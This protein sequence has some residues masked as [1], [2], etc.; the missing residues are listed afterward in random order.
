M[1]LCSQNVSLTSYAEYSGIS[2]NS[3]KDVDTLIEQI[4]VRI[5]S[6]IDDTDII[7]GHSLEN[8]LRAL[9]L[10]H[11]KII[12][13][14]VI[15]RGIN[16]RKFSLKHLSTVLLQRKIQ[17]GCGSYGHCSAEDAEA[18]LVLALRRARRG[19]SF[20][21]KENPK[22]S[23][24]LST[25]QRVNRGDSKQSVGETFA[26]RNDG[27]CV[28]IG[29]NGWIMKYAGRSDGAHHMLSCESIINSMAMAVPSWL[30][31]EQSSKR[32]GFLWANLCCEDRSTNGK[33][34]DE[35][36]RLDD[37]MKAIV[38]R[39]PHH[40]PILLIFQHNYQ[41]ALALTQQ[42]KAARNPKTTCNWTTQQ[43][44]EWKQCIE[45]CRNCEAIW[46]GSAG[47]SSC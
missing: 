1:L 22:Q 2:P 19:D 6:L 43:D 38:D 39:V 14:S 12:D 29:P 27:S 24:I 46:I 33:F 25:F 4:Q 31:S 26:E 17:Q 36:K 18:A 45:Q 20:R 23:N 32:A 16:G 47:P 8:D 21:L 9:R 11:T 10:V 3:L 41:K 44:E 42:R 13:T 15:F 7:V 35:K 40:T 28:C 34:L 5:L 37:I 30:S